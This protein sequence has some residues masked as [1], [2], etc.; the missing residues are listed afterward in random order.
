MFVRP[1][2]RRTIL[3]TGLPMPQQLRFRCHDAGPKATR[4]DYEVVA[5]PTHRAR[6]RGPAFVGPYLAW[7]YYIE[8]LDLVLIRKSATTYVAI[9]NPEW[10]FESHDPAQPPFT[11]SGSFSILE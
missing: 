5:E 6:Q 11:N 10:V 7:Q 8:K 3:T 9:D 4:S 1:A 2:L